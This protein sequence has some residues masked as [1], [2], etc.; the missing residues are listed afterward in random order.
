MTADYAADVVADARAWCMDVVAD[1]EALE[2]AAD[3]DVMRFVAR[4]YCGG[5]AAFLQDAAP[6]GS[7]R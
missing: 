4:N 1:P 6:A 5:V 2:D 3:A 7:W